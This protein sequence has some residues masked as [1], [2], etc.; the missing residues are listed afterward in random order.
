[1]PKP[2]W[3]FRLDI[4]LDQHPKLGEFAEQMGVCHERALARIVRFWMGVREHAADGII[5]HLS[6]TT[7]AGWMR[8]PAGKEK[9]WVDAL[10]TAGFIVD[11]KVYGWLERQGGV[12]REVE[13]AR[14]RMRAVRG[15]SPDPRSGNGTANGSPNRPKTVRGENGEQ[16]ENGSRLKLG[17]Q[18]T[19]T[20]TDTNNSTTLVGSPPTGHDR[21]AELFAKWNELASKLGLPTAEKIT[22]KR[23]A[24]AKARIA[25]GLL[26]RWPE[27]AAALESWRHGLGHNDR[28]WKANPVWLLRPDAW[29][30]VIENAAAPKSAAALPPRLFGSG[31]PESV[32]DWFRRV[33]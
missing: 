6:D 5:S 14:E 29:L 11:G 16:A 22:P 4:T 7:I 30:G 18:S 23:T 15:K 17:P 8:A 26:D 32:E 31:P 28:G 1:M 10:R 24:A 20:S 21:V 27:F 9:K 13:R 19:S 25:E 3:W 12:I 33:S 2:S